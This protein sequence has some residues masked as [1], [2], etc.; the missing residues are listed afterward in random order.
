ML[1]FVLCDDNSNFLINLENT[2]NKLFIKNDFDAKVS[3]KS[4][5]V[6]DVIDYIQNN[7]VDVLFLDIHL[8]SHINGIDVAEKIRKNNKNLYII[9]TTCHFEYALLA[10]H[11][12][13]FDYLPKPIASDRLESTLIRIFDDIN[14]SSAKFI[15]LNNKTYIK[16][17]DIYF[18]K[19]D[20]M[21]LVFQ[22]NSDTYEI[23]SSFSKLSPLLPDNF[24][25]CHKSYIVNVNNITS[26]KANNN[27]ITFENNSECYIGPKYKSDFLGVISNGK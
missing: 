13:A 10:F 3:F 12:K 5:N 26:I 7:K 23:Y 19:R 20:G 9:F 2:L 14:G 17:D 6:P 22:T 27:L 1:N 11:V 15:S 8:K 25:R 21:K 16:E 24:I 18:I 4:T